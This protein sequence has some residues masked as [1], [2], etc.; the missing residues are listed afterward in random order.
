VWKEKSAREFLEVLST[1]IPMPKSNIVHHNH[2]LRGFKRMTMIHDVD[3]RVVLMLSTMPTLVSQGRV[4]HCNKWR[5]REDT[6]LVSLK[7]AH[8]LPTC[9][10]IKL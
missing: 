1:W 7:D 2:T 4:I 10:T 5:A 3:F 6:R 8:N 9:S